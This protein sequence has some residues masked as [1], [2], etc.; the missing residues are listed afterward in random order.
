MRKAKESM[1]RSEYSEELFVAICAEIACG[2]SVEVAAQKHDVSERAFYL[3]LTKYPEAVQNYARAREV[4]SD[5]R[6]E[7]S[8]KLMADLK[9][10]EIDAQ[11]ARVMLD[12]IK[13]KC[14]KESSRKYGDKVDVTTAGES[15][16]D[17]A[18][19]EARIA[20][21]LGKAGAAIVV[22]AAGAMESTEQTSELPPV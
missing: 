19:T 8:S 6:F 21:L 10:G 12:E 4:R 15:L 1:P 11:Q 13:W 18:T 16:N 3:W 20:Q 9:L 2:D 22:G 7:S 5:A 17:P 14:G